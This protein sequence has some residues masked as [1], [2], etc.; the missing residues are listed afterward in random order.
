MKYHELHSGRN[1][2]LK[3]KLVLSIEILN[4]VNITVDTENFIDCRFG[5]P[6]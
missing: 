4:S 6:L 5:K 2:R 1:N 3:K